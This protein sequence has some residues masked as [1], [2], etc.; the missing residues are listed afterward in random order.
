MTYFTNPRD[1]CR[2]FQFVDP[3]AINESE[4]SLAAIDSSISFGRLRSSILELNLA[5]IVPS[6]YIHT[7]FVVIHSKKNNLDQAGGSL[8]LWLWPRDSV[9]RPGIIP[10]TKALRNSSV[11]CS[12]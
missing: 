7:S 2:R 10:V 5:Q 4:S 8:E 11:G 3:S 6:I 1:T 9:S 12:I